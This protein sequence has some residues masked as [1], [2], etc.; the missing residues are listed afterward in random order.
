MASG[1]S[2]PPLRDATLVDVDR[3][4][5]DPDNPRLVGLSPKSSQ[6]SII[7]QLYKS[8]ELSELL[9]SVAANG[10]LDIEPLI[11]LGK[12]KSGRMLVLEGNRRL[13]TVML[14]R[15]SDLV[16]RIRESEGLRVMVPE[17]PERFWESLKQV[18]VYR[19]ETREEARAFIG[20]KHINGAAKWDSYAKAKFAASWHREGGASLED[21][22]DKIGDKHDTIVRMV[23]AIF[24]LDQAKDAGVFSI[25]DR[26]SPK[27]SFSHLYT[28]LS[29]ANYAEFLG[30]PRA[31]TT[32]DP[33]PN[34]VPSERLPQL[35]EVLTWIYGSKS[36][37]LRPEVR[38]QNPDIK[39][40]G[41]VLAHNEAL[42]VLRAGSGLDVAYQS[43]QP[44]TEVFSTSLVTARRYT[45]AAMSNLGGFDGLDL[46]LLTIAGD[47]AES[48][49]GLLDLMRSKVRKVDESKN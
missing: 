47:L 14:F 21:V 49:Q 8:Q 40:L 5:L 15:D 18:S 48:S 9:Q 30:I 11:V 31:W 35:G 28:A 4:E 36:S 2:L 27:F 24:V 32:S 25:D 37:A 45:K 41:D 13:A 10:Y 34:P 38:T 26:A 23:G 3:L 16:A 17:L 46:S 29:R 22:A 39:K 43:A 33:K 12:G 19:V 44:A 20:F 42:H 1:T 7:A 6:E